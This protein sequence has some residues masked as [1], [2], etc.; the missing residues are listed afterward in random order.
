M[1]NLSP[2][3]IAWGI[4]ALVVIVLGFMRKNVSAEEDDTLHLG[5]GSEQAVAHQQ[6][7]AKKLAALDKWGK[8][9]TVL[10]AVT[11]VV[12]TIAY[13]MQMWESTKSTGV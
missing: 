10:L 1:V 2:F 5:G 9:L 8:L 3:V 6:A 12:L 4:L 11:G 13:F 7:V